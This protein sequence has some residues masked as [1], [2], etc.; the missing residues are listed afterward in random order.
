MK[1]NSLSPCCSWVI[2]FDEKSLMFDQ[3]EF[4]SLIM[5]PVL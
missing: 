2:A 4:L 1:F 3:G 5:F